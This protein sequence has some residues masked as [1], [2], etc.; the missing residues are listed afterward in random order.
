MDAFKQLWPWSREN[1]ERQTYL[2]ERF[3]MEEESTVYV[4]P[5]R[6]PS[7]ANI[8]A[9]KPALKL[10]L[11]RMSRTNYHHLQWPEI[12]TWYCEGLSMATEDNCAIGPDGALKDASEMDWQHSETEDQPAADAA[13]STLNASARQHSKSPLLSTL[14]PSRLKKPTWKKAEATGNAARTSVSS[15][16]KGFFKPRGTDT[17]SV[18]KEA[19]ISVSALEPPKPTSSQFALAKRQVLRKK[20][21]AGDGS[22]TDESSSVEEIDIPTTKKRRTYS[23]SSHAASG[24]DIDIEGGASM[25]DVNADGDNAES[26]NESEPGDKVTAYERMRQEK[27]EETQTSK[28]RST[29]DDDE[30]TRDV[31]TI[32]KPDTRLHKDGKEEK[33][34]WCRVCRDRKM[35]NEDCWFTGGVSSLRTHIKRKWASHGARYLRKCAEQGLTP[36]HLAVPKPTTED[37]NEGGSKPTLDSF[38]KKVP[39]WTQQGLLDHIVE[40][41]VSDDQA[42]RL[43]E[44]AAFRRLLQYQRP[45]TKD[46]EIPHHTFVRE[47]I[48]RKASDVEARL[49]EVFKDI[50][51]QI[52]VTFD[53]W[54]SKAYDPYLSVTAHYIDS[55]PGKPDEWELKAKVI[56]FTEIEGNHSGANTA[57]VVLHVVDRYGLRGK[58]GWL[59]S[60]NASTNDKAMRVLQWVLNRKGRRWLAKQRQ[61]RCMEHIMHLGAKAVIDAICPN[62]AFRK[63]KNVE[64]S[65]NDDTKDDGDDDDNEWIAVAEEEVP[66]DEEVNEAVDFDAGDLLGKILAFV[67]QVRASPQ[68]K[69][70][71]SKVCEEEGLKPLELIK[72]VRTRWG[73]MC[74]LIKRILDNKLAVMKFCLVAD[75]SKKVP[76]LRNKE[77]S[78]YMV[79]ESEWQLLELIYEV[80]AEPREAQAAFSS[81]TYS[82]VWRAIPTLECLQERWETMAKQPKFAS[83]KFAIDA[84][85]EKLRKW[86][87]AID[88]SDMY[89]ICLALDPTYKV[90]Y[91]KRNWDDRYHQ[92]GM[93]AFRKSDAPLEDS[94]KITD[95]VHWWGAHSSQ[96]PVLS[97]IARDYLAIQ[98]SAVASER[99]F[100]SGGRTG[101]ALRNHLA[102]ATFEAL[103]ILK[104][105]YRDGI[106]SA[107][108]AVAQAAK[109]SSDTD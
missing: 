48:M 53:A 95:P 25:P 91:T 22:S 40:L 1:Y 85:L 93:I 82:T 6:V 77:Y 28:K 50:P 30:Q 51:G 17:E 83:I 60:D 7:R 94:E 42:F 81:E 18:A 8:P 9:L 86:Y 58:L 89:F 12:S 62:P 49:R 71:F 76:K 2:S 37:L 44:K 67:N 103:Q 100:S 97:R 52:S 34:H 108:E 72:W 105:G 16:I 26:D 55:P 19:Q 88:D 11:A 15:T 92:D 96:Y 32:F 66:D 99:A 63:V 4:P 64:D 78:D 65:N 84:G 59:T 106:V 69:S 33:G 21:A 29:R 54:T 68:A 24:M 57:A 75:A 107:V 109:E 56:G 5:Q 79:T 38:V 102:S 23:T 61:G 27:D 13:S 14:R 47:E 87:K 39:K 36:N 74:N 104:S 10:G 90:E 3:Q 35:K 73:S 101:T 45:Q 80:L 31:R 98:G 43:V 46:T 70:Y 41:I 20:A